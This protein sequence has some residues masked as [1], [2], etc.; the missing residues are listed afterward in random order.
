MGRG[1]GEEGVEA[2]AAAAPWWVEGRR[3]WGRAGAGEAGRGLL[4]RG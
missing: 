4:V 1:L 3:G 2:G